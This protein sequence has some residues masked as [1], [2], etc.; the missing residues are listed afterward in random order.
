MNSNRDT[1]EEVEALMTL[2]D[3]PV[4]GL[5]LATT[6]L[7][8]KQ[9]ERA[10]GAAPC[11]FFD[12]I[13]TGVG[14]ASVGVMNESGMELLVDHLVEHGHRRIALLAGMQTETTGIERLRGFRAAM[15]RHG[16]PVTRGH[17]RLSDWTQE[18]GRLETRA[19]LG[20]RTRPTAIIA[21]SDDLAFG[22]F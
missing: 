19:L 18:S 12:G 16:L 8:A 13:L 21:A 4:D 11:V 20:L 6:G 3:H 15:K 10:V 14:T 5:L 9:F 22:C 2:L 7:G 17:V 1:G